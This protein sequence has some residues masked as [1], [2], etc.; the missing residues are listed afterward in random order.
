M[1]AV[2]RD[3]NLTDHCTY[4]YDYSKDSLTSPDTI[5]NNHRVANNNIDVGCL[6]PSDYYLADLYFDI[7]ITDY[8][9]ACRREHMACNHHE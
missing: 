5:V 1:L 2:I 9:A 6:R 4:P 8:L 7:I 3:S